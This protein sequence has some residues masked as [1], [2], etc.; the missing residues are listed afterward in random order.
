VLLLGESLPADLPPAVA[1]NSQMILA[2]IPAGLPSDLL[3]R[4]PDVLQAEA[5]LRAANASIGA[6]R[7]AFFPTISLTG[8]RHGELVALGLFKSGSQAWSFAP[9]SR[10]RSSTRQPAGQPGCGDAAKDIDIAQYEKAIQ[11][12]FREVADGL[13]A[14][15]TYDDQVASLER[16]AQASNARSICRRCDSATAWTII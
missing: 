8:I 7:A 13:A 4:R 2:D 10:F 16:Y 11:T 3:A 9:R 12:A 14:R 1:L 6:A 15:G 5:T